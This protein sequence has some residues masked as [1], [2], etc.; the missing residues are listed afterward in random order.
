MNKE[1]SEGREGKIVLALVVLAALFVHVAF[2][3]AA[4]AAPVRGHPVGYGTANPLQ[5]LLRLNLRTVVG[6]VFVQLYLRIT[7]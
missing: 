5:E 3:T 6:Q 1:S 2:V 4:G 7:R